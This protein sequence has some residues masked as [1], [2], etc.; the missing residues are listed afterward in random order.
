MIIVDRWLQ[1]KQ[2]FI[3]GKVLYEILGTDAAMKNLFA[4]GESAFAKKKLHD[5]LSALN[6]KKMRRTLTAYNLP[7]TTAMPDSDD[8]VLHSL[9]T[10]WKEKYARM[11]LLRHKLDEYGERNDDDAR[12]CMQRH[13]AKKFVRQSK[14]LCSYGN[15]EMSICK[16]VACLL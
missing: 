3:V 16:Q 11:N 7:L 5:V 10:D 8:K 6:E 4:K 9:N 12:E 15:S 13:Y 2:N 14:R 1:G